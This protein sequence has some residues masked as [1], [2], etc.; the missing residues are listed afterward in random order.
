MST[1]PGCV[2]HVPMPID[3]GHACTRG[4]NP[5]SGDARI[6]QHLR[7]SRSYTVG[8]MPAELFIEKFLPPVPAERKNEILSSR[9]A[10]SGIPHGAS[11]PREIFQPLLD[12]LNKSTKHKSRAPGLVFEN[13]S[14]RSEQPHELGFMKPHICCY[15]NANAEAVRRTPITSRADLGY[16]ELFVEVKPDALLDFFVDPPS[17]AT[18]EAIAAH[19]FVAKYGNSK[20]KARVDRAFGQHIMYSAEILARQ[21]RTFVF[22]ITMAGSSARLCRWDRSGL[23]VSRSF[24]ICERPELLCDFLARFACAS[25][26]QRGHDDTVEMATLEEETLFRDAVT[27]HVQKQLGVEGDA[28]AIAVVEHYKAGHVMAMHVHAVDTENTPG[29]CTRG[30]WAVHAET[31]RVVFLK[32]TWRRPDDQE[33][34]II[35]ELNA[36]GV[37]NIPTV[38]AHGDVYVNAPPAGKKLTLGEVGYGLERLKGTRE[39]LSATYD[40]FHAMRDASDKASRIHR[41]ISV[42]NIV[43][44]REV[45]GAPRKGYLIDWEMSDKVDE[46]GHALERART[47]TWRF[48]S[49]K[50]LEYPER[51]H[52]LQDDMESLL[53]VV[54]YCSLL[55]LPHDVRN[56]ENL[57]T[58]I[59]N[60]FDSSSFG[61]GKLHGGDAKLANAYTRNWIQ[62]VKFNS[63][64]ITDWLNTVMNYHFPPRNLRRE[65]ADRWSNPDYLDTFWGTFLERRELE[66]DDAVR[67]EVE[68]LVSHLY[69]PLHT[70][71]LRQSPANAS[72]EPLPHNLSDGANACEHPGHLLATLTNIRGAILP[73]R[74]NAANTGDRSRESIDVGALAVNVVTRL[75]V[76]Y[77]PLPT[78]SQPQSE[79]DFADHVHGDWGEVEELL[80]ETLDG[81]DNPALGNYNVPLALV[82]NNFELYGHSSKDSKDRYARYGHEGI[83]FAL[84]PIPPRTFLETF[85]PCP[86]EI[87]EKMPSATDA[88][89]RV[90]GGA[91]TEEEIYEPLITALNGA[92]RCPGYTFSDTSSHPDTAGN[93]TVKPDVLCYAN[94]HLS[95]VRVEGNVSHADMG[96]ATFFIEVKGRPTHD[97]FQDPYAHWGSSRAQ[98]CRLFKGTTKTERRIHLEN[99]GQQ[100]VYATELCA[101]QFR[102]F[103]FSVSIYG[104][105]ARIMRWDRAGLIVT[106]QFDLHDNPE[107]LCEFVWRYA[108]MSEAQRGMDMS[109]AAASNDEEALFRAAVESHVALQLGLLGKPLQTAIYRHYQPKAVC[110]IGVFDVATLQE[111]RYLVSRPLSSPLSITG[112]ATRTYWAVN[113]QTGQ[114]VYLKDTWR[115]CTPGA[116]QEGV[117]IA[118]LAAAGVRHIPVVLHHGDVPSLLD[119][120]PLTSFD[121]AVKQTT[122]THQYVDAK[123]ACEDEIDLST[124]VKYT[125]YRL[126]GSVAGYP[127]HTIIDAFDK[128][129]VHRNIHPSSVVLYREKIGADRQG[130]L[131]DWDLSWCRKATNPHARLPFDAMWQFMSMSVQGKSEQGHS[132]QDDMESLLYVMLYCGLRWLDHTTDPK[133]EGLSWILGGL[134]DHATWWHREPHGYD[135]KLANATGRKYTRDVRF[136]SPALHKW[137]NKLMDFHH[138]QVEEP[139]KSGTQY[140]SPEPQLSTSAEWLNPKA[141]EELW[142]RFLEVEYLERDDRVVRTLPHESREIDEGGAAHPATTPSI[143][144]SAKRSAGEP[145]EGT[146]AGPSKKRKGSS[147]RD[148]DLRASTSLHYLRTGTLERITALTIPTDDAGPSTSAVAP[149][150]RKEIPKRH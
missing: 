99:F 84:G 131:L 27:M 11:T 124:I 68:R 8:P 109:V 104:R 142:T 46:H 90:P 148:R 55:Y 147:S 143:S 88:F 112:R 115:I 13:A 97:F 103:C 20:M 2:Y 135:G 45:D 94:E 9:R 117:V 52:T 67:N 132:I 40:A 66:Q 61:F 101:R 144:R 70:N 137:L 128:K 35:N 111:H 85:C 64:N 7:D 121:S 106:R 119:T 3:D 24:D 49:T 116:E 6:K 31:R 21:H 48:M 146:S 43:L 78:M 122:I 36:A 105:K 136:T 98:P 126:V 51:G 123:W 14:D 89:I 58:F 74:T 96:F 47:G 113:A 127:L 10:F 92:G 33:G 25:N 145:H 29:R 69:H 41:D 30:Y 77:T 62:R 150:T 141:L 102:H 60:F 140:F 81:P 39:L 16:A 15:T 95:R 34:A 32:D 91:D 22:S 12:A 4:L 87:V 37:R 114:V 44:V 71:Q 82:A 59:Y 125:Q 1:T 53:Y 79:P 5:S 18:A 129:R 56:P 138:P 65:W 80:A 38:V 75:P 26:N 108:H 73:A 63:E 76:G 100:I 57:H 28:L 42:G 149:V 50:I 72:V 19:E 134:F 139:A 130:F 83:G 86:V 54:L 133:S 118:S 23:I 120:K 17:D 110:A 107:I 93:C